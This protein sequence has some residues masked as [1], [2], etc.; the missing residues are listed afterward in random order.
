[1]K[2]GHEARVFEMA[3]HSAPNCKQKR[4][5]KQNNR[6]KQTSHIG[7]VIRAT[8]FFNLSRNIVIASW[9]SVLRVLPGLWPTCLATK[10]S[11]ARLGNMLRKVD[12]SYT[13]C[14]KFWFCCTYYHWSFKLSRNKFE[15]NACD[16]L[17][18]S[19]ET[20]QIKNM[21]AREDSLNSK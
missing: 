2:P 1:M 19:P 18:R 9:N 11:V 7:P 20:R 13:F 17:S 15:F 4:Q 16:W 8:F 21:A 6:G 5:P 12:S 14:N 3:P 10:Y